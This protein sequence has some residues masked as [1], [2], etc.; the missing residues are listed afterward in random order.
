MQQKRSNAQHFCEY[1]C[2]RQKVSRTSWLAQKLIVLWF[3]NSPVDS[4]QSLCSARFA[5]ADLGDVHL[6]KGRSFITL[7]LRGVLHFA[8]FQV[9]EVCKAWF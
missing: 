4:I 7:T 6:I 5:L 9:S 2:P 1:D 3:Y 8:N